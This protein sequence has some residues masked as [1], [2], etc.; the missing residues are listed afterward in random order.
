MAAQEK[1]MGEVRT[2]MSEMTTLIMALTAAMWTKNFCDHFDAEVCAQIADAPALFQFSLGGRPRLLI[3]IGRPEL[4]SIPTSA[5][6]P[7]AFRR[8]AR[9][10]AR[11]PVEKMDAKLHSQSRG[12]AVELDLAASRHHH[13]RARPG[14]PRGS[15]R[16]ERRRQMI[17]LGG[18]FVGAYP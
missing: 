10:Y 6:A 3:E 12:L 17:G 15:F 9:E 18:L 7:T 8:P 14:R 1:L 13:A 5:I 16:D 2:A 11:R 4:C